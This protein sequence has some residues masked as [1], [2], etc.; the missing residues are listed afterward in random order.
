MHVGQ[1]L[2]W[3][4]PQQMAPAYAGVS[5]ANPSMTRL[6]GGC[7]EAH[8]HNSSCR[9]AFALP[10]WQLPGALPVWNLLSNL[11]CM[12]VNSKCTWHTI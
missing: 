4:R 5:H 7:Q 2:E 9:S 3:V 8:L 11:L 6:A 1:I 10:R 12:S